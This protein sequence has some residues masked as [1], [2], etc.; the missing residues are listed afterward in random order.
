LSNG[1][2][3]EF[4]KLRRK[5]WINQQCPEDSGKIDNFFRLKIAGTG[6]KKDDAAIRPLSI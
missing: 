5:D 2:D 4:C 3:S 6:Q 1:E